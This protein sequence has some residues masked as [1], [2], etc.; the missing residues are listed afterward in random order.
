MFRLWILCWQINFDEV[1][2]SH[3]SPCKQRL[4]DT[5]WPFRMNT[6]ECMSYYMYF[7]SYMSS[8]PAIW[9][10]SGSS[11]GSCVISSVFRTATGHVGSPDLPA[12]CTRVQGVQIRALRKSGRGHA[13]SY[14]Q[15]EGELY[16][17]GRT[18]RQRDQPDLARALATM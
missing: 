16:C 11:V 8:C 15:S 7:R 10:L 12:G 3:F 6:S 14:S 4:N 13:V 17:V 9:F 18:R 2:F 1:W 5:W